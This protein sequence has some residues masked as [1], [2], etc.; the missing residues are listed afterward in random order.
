MK[1]SV[2]RDTAS[3]LKL[4]NIHINSVEEQVPET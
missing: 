4:S 2:D 1:A 3:F